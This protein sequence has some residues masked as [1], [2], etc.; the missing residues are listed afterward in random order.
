MTA[1]Q[2]VV[3]TTTDGRQAK[4]SWTDCLQLDYQ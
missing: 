3:I 2:E 1:S 4:S